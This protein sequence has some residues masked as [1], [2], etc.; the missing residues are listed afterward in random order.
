MDTIFHTFLLLGFG[1]VTGVQH[2][3]DLDHIAAITD[4]T[5]AQRDRK[6]SIWYAAL[7]GLGH[8]IVVV[9]LGVILI[10][11]G[12]SIPQSLDIL[13]GKLV[14]V[15]LIVLG[16]YV[17]YSLYRHGRNFTLKSRWMLFFD[18]IKFDYHRFLHNFAF[19]HKHHGKQKETY[20]PQ[21]A[22]A[23]GMI[24]GVGAQTPT[25]IS[26]L[27]ALLGIKDQA[28]AIAFLFAFVFG[29]FIANIALAGILSSALGVAQKWK[30]VYIAVGLI[31]AL[32]SIGIGLEFIF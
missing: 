28:V 11:I 6:R 15:T 32:F 13:F 30:R 31:A 29:I 27:A 19:S 14:G 3:I 4:M 25:Q 16:V 24:H 21:S 23:I 7:Y 18:V 20:E 10:A 1:F 17:L 9:L 2:G 5:S 12:Q 8:G 26:V 22:F